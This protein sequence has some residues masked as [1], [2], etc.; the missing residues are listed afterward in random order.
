[1]RQN[2]FEI[3]NAKRSPS[4]EIKR[5]DKL[6]NKKGGVLVADELLSGF[7]KG[8]PTSIIEYVDDY[9]FKS[10]ANRGTCVDCNDLEQTL[11][12]SELPQ[13][14]ADVSEHFAMAFCEYAANMIYLLR[15]KLHQG[16]KITDIVSAAEENIKVFLSWYNYELRNYPDLQKVLIV[17]KNAGAT[18]VAEKMQ[19]NSLAYNVIEYNHFQ[20]QGDIEKKKAILL[21]IGADLEPKRKELSDLNKELEDNIFFMLNNLNIRHNNRKKA[22]NTMC[23][24][25]QICV[26]TAWKHGTIDC[27]S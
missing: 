24:R 10:W 1:M 22:T 12:I 18:V 6:L 23:Q 14:D 13:S 11:D 5:I 16:D 8:T 27:T 3:V 20:L 19:D 15:C 4:A 2:I 9:L 7:T 25:S 17:S 26:R 21:S